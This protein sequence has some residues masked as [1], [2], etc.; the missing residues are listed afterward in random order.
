MKGKMKAI[1]R[2]RERK[3]R[4]QREKERVRDQREMNERKEEKLV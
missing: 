1:D 2:G 4:G 3:K